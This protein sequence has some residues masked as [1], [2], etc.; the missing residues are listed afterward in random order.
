MRMPAQRPLITSSIALRAIATGVTLLS[1]ACMTAFAAT[2]VQ[3][4]AAPL[5][6]AA[7]TGTVAAVTTATPKAATTSSRRTTVTSSVTTTTTSAKT[8]THSS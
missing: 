4:T 1:T 5:Q 8:K 6:P 3:N 7:S 2:H